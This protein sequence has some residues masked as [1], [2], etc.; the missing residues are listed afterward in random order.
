MI[1]SRRGNDP[2]ILGELN[3]LCRE[4][5]LFTLEEDRGNC[6]GPFHPDIIHCIADQRGETGLG[7]RTPPGGGDI[8]ARHGRG[9]PAER[10]PTHRTTSHSL[11]SIDSLA[12]P[13]TENCR[14]FPLTLF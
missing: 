10:T 6:L 2:F 1:R 11:N 7:Q 4:T 5:Y 8:E 13:L 9:A 12:K 14:L 3:H